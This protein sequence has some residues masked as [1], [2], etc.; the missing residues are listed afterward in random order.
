M[1]NLTNTG[2]GT[3]QYCD[4]LVYITED[5][6]PN[7]VT[8]GVSAFANCTGL[9]DVEFPAVTTVSNNSFN[10]CTNLETFE[11]GESQVTFTTPFASCSKLESLIINSTTM[12]TLS[13]AT[14]LAGTA[15]A[16]FKGAVY[17]PN[18]LLATYKANANWKNYFI[19]SKDDYPVTEYPDPSDGLGTGTITDTWAEIIANENYAT[20]YAIG[21]T[22]S[23]YLEGFGVFNMELVAIDTDIRA[24]GDETK[25][26]GKAGMTWIMKE[27]FTTHKMN[28]S[29]TNANGW[30]VTDMR[31]WL[32]GTILRLF[33]QTVRDNI[34]KVTKTYYDYTTKS[35]LSG[36]DTIWIPSAREIF[37]G[38]SYEDSGVDYTAKFNN[39][40]NRKKYLNE[41]ASNWYLRSA[42]SNGSIQFWCINNSGDGASYNAGNA[43]GVAPGF[44]L[45]YITPLERLCSALDDGTYVTKYH[46]NDTVPIELDGVTYTGRILAIDTDVDANNNPIPVTIGF[47]ELLPTVIQ[48]NTTNTNSG[49]W[50]ASAG[51]TTVAGYESKL[52][53]SVQLRLVAVKK[54]SYNKTTNADQITYD[55]LW[56]P[57]FK[58]LGFTSNQESGG[59]VYSGVYT[60]D[61]SRVKKLSG[62]NTS[63]W[64]RTA[65]SSSTNYF[66][67][68]HSS[69]VAGYNNASYSFGV[70]LC[71]CL[72]SKPES[73]EEI[74]WDNL[75]K[76]IQN[77]TVTTDY[78]LGDTIPYTTTDGDT[79]HAQIVGFGK[80]VDADGNTIP[81]SFITQELW[82]TKY[83]M[84]STNTNSGGWNAS[85][86]RTSTMPACKFRL[87][88]YV[89]KHIVAA[90][91]YSYD[92]TTS[93][94]QTTVDEVWIP[95]YKEL[96]FT[97]G[98]E[99]GGASYSEVFNDNSARIKKLNG[100]NTY[101]WTRTA[102]SS[103][104]GGFRSVETSGKAGYTGSSNSHGVALGFCLG[105]KPKSIEE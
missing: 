19:F 69:G 48:M 104:T 52:P 98:Q 17:V 21:A 23:I 101:Y 26:G 13:T 100:T 96:G 61:S 4:G 10:G 37:G 16:N 49:G 27:V 7:L 81:V 97:S 84:N 64:T 28:I 54:Y 14:G 22:K 57:N 2:T 40:T 105:S 92:K 15:I 45:S 74:A 65:E 91:K 51:R 80:D 36:S 46:V 25:N 89:T 39:A 8:I 60:S 70:A 72:G 85:F 68:A 103:S 32:T 102:S 56:I 6:F 31:D 34:V 11:T 88:E 66:R 47:D 99:S 95:N 82:N 71:F 18:N 50:E 67:I 43:Y 87:P 76:S 75:H 20:D 35:T 86:M 30:P 33:P 55:K 9:E 1:P 94:E 90:K 59:P 29:S 58:E 78:S 63:Y 24:D 41:S 44:C 38:T 93:S 53:A 12:S 73:A 83:L 77:G 79:Y 3:F 42:P 62:S 5:Q